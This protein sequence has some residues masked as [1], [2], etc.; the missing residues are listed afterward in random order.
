MG[1]DAV[2]G[3][4]QCTFLIRGI[5]PFSAAES[6]GCLDTTYKST[7][8]MQ[9]LGSESVTAASMSCARSSLGR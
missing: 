5:S 9:D 1:A 3:R 8:G 7:N 4:P 2:Q 6:M